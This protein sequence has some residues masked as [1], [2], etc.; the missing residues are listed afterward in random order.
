M[1]DGIEM[2]KLKRI[3]HKLSLSN[4]VTFFGHLSGNEKIEVYKKSHI[5]VLPSYTEGFPNVILEA[6]SAGLAI[7]ATPV[8]AL[9]DLLSDRKFGLE[10][11]SNPPSPVEIFKILLKFIDNPVTCR[12]FGQYSSKLAEKKFNIPIV[13]NSIQDIYSQLSKV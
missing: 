3:S 11:K 13:I 8:G 5:F 10:I 9:Q 6:M 1:G 12:K 4:S 2:D 7:V